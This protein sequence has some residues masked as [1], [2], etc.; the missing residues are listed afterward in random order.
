MK[1]EGQLEPPL[2]PARAI[3][4]LSLKAPMEWT[5]EFLDYDDA[6]ISGPSRALFGESA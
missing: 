5:G 4:W 2:V 6:R 3:A 1:D